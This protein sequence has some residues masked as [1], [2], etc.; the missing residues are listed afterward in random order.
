MK[1]L[2]P[3]LGFAAC[4][5]M[6]GPYDRPYAIITTD[7]AP[8]ADPLLLP[9]IVNRVDGETVASDNRAVVAP[10]A[11]KVTVDV[12]PRRGFHTATQA[13]FDLAA[14]PCR[15]YYVAAK[16]ESRTSQ[17]WVPVVRGVEA[18]GECEAKF[19]IAAKK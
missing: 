15:R 17:R 9:V 12:P 10:G 2:L 3:V 6:A 7:R 8:S 13:T 14:E 5:A 16:L 11:H 1:R 4:A 18:I 19:A